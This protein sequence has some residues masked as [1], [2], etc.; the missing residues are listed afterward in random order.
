MTMGADINAARQSEVVTVSLRARA[1]AA[2]D[3]RW[4]V[5]LV[6]GAVLL[7]IFLTLMR[8]P[9]PFVDEGW[10]ANRSWALL[11]TGRPFGTL[12]SGVFERYPGYWTYF[13]LIGASIHAASI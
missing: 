11:H 6:F 7:V 9:A 1:Q 8:V 5:V 13:P 10:N 4:T 2:V 3:S 12:D